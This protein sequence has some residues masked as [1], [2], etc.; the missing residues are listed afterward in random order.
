MKGKQ[1]LF[2]LGFVFL[3]VSTFFIYD[4]FVSYGEFDRNRSKI[5]TIEEKRREIN[6]DNNRI[7]LKIERFS[8]DSRAA[9]ELLREKF[10]MLRKDQYKYKYTPEK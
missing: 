2:V 9:E 1:K 8:K 4:T 3:F 7:R 10:K 5:N 6:R